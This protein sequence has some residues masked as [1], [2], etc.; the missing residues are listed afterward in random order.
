MNMLNK[1]GKSM[2]RSSLYYGG[3][4]LVIMGLIGIVSGTGPAWTRYSVLGL[5]IISLLIFN[6]NRPRN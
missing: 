6:I 5:G 4:I 2:R 1:Y 3:L